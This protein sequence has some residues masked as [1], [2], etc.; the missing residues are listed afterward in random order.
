MTKINKTT[1]YRTWSCPS[2]RLAT[3]VGH[4]QLYE[5]NFP[6][7]Y[8]TTKAK[9]TI[10]TSL[11]SLHVYHAASIIYVVYIE[12]YLLRGE[13]MFEGGD[14]DVRYNRP[15]SD[16]TLPRCHAPLERAAAPGLPTA[17]SLLSIYF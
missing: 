6:S 12:S 17:A 3:A 14:D 15:V 13:E 11:D 16:A 4:V 10:L 7:L 1:E 9:A 8:V 5:Y 2:S